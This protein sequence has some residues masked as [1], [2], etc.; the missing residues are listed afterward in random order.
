MLLSRLLFKDEPPKNP[1]DPKIP[2]DPA[3][4]RG[5]KPTVKELAKEHRPG[6]GYAK[7]AKKTNTVFRVTSFELFVKPNMRVAVPGTLLFAGSI[8]YIGYMYWQAGEAVEKG[9]HIH[10]YNEH[11]E[12]RMVVKDPNRSKWD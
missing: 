7:M 6:E 11:G 4:P 5:T 8:G 2:G 3:P 10:G 12:K 9:T 1:S